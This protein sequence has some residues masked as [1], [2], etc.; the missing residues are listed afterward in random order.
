VHY[1]CL[2]DGRCLDAKLFY[3]VYPDSDLYAVRPRRSD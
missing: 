1:A 2:R 3:Q